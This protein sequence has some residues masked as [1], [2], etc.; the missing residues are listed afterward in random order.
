VGTNSKATGE[1]RRIGPPECGAIV[2]GELWIRLVEAESTP[3]GP[4]RR[5]VGRRHAPKLFGNHNN[6]EPA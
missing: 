2:K 5:L 6:P 3:D 4:R 1:M